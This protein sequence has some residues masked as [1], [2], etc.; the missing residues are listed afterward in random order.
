M[1]IRKVQRFLDKLNSHSVA[2]NLLL[3][4]ITVTALLFWIKSL[5]D[6]WMQ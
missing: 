2:V 1:L 3:G 4:M 6:M 5:H